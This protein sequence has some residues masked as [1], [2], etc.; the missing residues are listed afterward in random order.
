MTDETLLLIGR[1]T[2][3]AREVFE[4]HAERLRDSGVVDTVR[5]VVY[6]D[7]PIRELG[8]TFA[9][10]AA[11]VVYA[12]PLVV[13][14]THETT[15]AIPTVLSSVTGDVCYCEPIGRS[16]AITG[17]LTDRASEQLQPDRDTSLVLV[18][19]GNSS[20]PYQRQVVEYHAERIRTR[21]PYEEVVP[22]YLIQD[23]AVE[24]ARYNVSSEEF[25]AVPVFVSRNEA[26]E[27]EIPSKLELDRGGMRYA[28]PLGTHHNL[29][30]AIHA[31]VEKQRVLRGTSIENGTD[32]QRVVTDGSGN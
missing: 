30:D 32:T 4:T 19:F 17:V 11:G 3:H 23:P 9:S 13:A 12:L 31:E 5:V 29:T 22:S 10:I 7:D 6:E 14:H 25:V 28:E 26:T 21:T 2:A 24:C 27:T 16:P 15:S 20:Q 18:G 1:D 8:E